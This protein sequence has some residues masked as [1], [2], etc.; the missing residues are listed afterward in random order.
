[1]KYS[2]YV[3]LVLGLLIQILT[4]LGLLIQK[5]D[6]AQGTILMVAETGKRRYKNAI[7]LGLRELPNV[8][9]TYNFLRNICKTHFTSQ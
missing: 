2:F 3:R 6:Y 7:V 8:S 9:V 5:H 4:V 1:M